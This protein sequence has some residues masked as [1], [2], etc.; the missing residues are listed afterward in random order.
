M[1]SADGSSSA[2]EG[3]IFSIP[4]T[5]VAGIDAHLR[6]FRSFVTGV[7]DPL[8]APPDANVRLVDVFAE[9]LSC[10]HRQFLRGV[11]WPVWIELPFE[12][13]RDLLAGLVERGAPDVGWRFLDDLNDELA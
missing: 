9:E 2:I 5:C 8:S 11:E 4:A 12:Q 6:V 10:E 13:F 3:N 7:I 1:S